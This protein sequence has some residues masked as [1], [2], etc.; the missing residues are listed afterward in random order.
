MLGMKRFGNPEERKPWDGW[1]TLGGHSHSLSSKFV[2]LAL[3]PFSSSPIKWI[4][5][6][7]MEPDLRA[8]GGVLA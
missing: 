5:L 3:P 6:G 8:F 7:P 2:C 4:E 1:W